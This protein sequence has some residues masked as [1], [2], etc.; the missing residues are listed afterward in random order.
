[1]KRDRYDKFDAISDMVLWFTAC[2]CVLLPT[3]W[4]IVTAFAIATD[5]AERCH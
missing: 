3:T 4:G 5:A 2:F 1:M